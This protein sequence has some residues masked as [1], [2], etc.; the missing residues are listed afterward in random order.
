MKPAVS[1][2]TG[3][4]GVLGKASPLADGRVA[5][6]VAACVVGFFR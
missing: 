5:V 2:L 1:V 3:S 4:A 6:L